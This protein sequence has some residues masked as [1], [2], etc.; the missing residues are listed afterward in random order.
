MS[1]AHHDKIEESF[2]AF[3]SPRETRCTSTQRMVSGAAHE[4]ELTLEMAVSGT[5]R[6]LPSP[7]AQPIPAL[8][9]H[10]AWIWALGLDV[11]N[12]LSMCHFNTIKMP[13]IPFTYL[14][15]FKINKNKYCYVLIQVVI[16]ELI[17][18]RI[19]DTC[20]KSI[21]FLVGNH[22]ANVFGNCLQMTQLDLC[23]VFA[24]MVGVW[25]RKIHWP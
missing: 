9:K 1:S 23:C 19:E 25:G 20:L 16:L 10:Q 18:L 4:Q 12:I 13:F 2:E 17:F 14:I 21:S 22:I 6:T 5:P 3:L 11:S 24:Q 15:L 7:Q 8:T